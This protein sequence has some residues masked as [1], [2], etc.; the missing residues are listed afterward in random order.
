MLSKAALDRAKGSFREM[1]GGDELEFIRVAPGGVDDYRFP[2]AL[3]GRPGSD[4]MLMWVDAYQ[5]ELDGRPQ[6]MA[7]SFD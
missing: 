3:F 1:A 6:R 4:E 2:A 5:W 7:W